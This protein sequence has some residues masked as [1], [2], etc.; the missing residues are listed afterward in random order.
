MVLLVRGDDKRSY[1]L[2]RGMYDADGGFAVT[3]TAGS[4]Q[5]KHIFARHS[6]SLCIMLDVRP[7]RSP[8]DNST[9]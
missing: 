8:H 3:I 9:L 7:L 5:T 2:L 1:C 4:C 6:S